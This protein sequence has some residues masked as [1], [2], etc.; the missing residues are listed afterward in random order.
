MCPEYRR[1]TL[2][3]NCLASCIMLMTAY[4]RRRASI[5]G[6]STLFIDQI[7]TFSR[8]FQPRTRV[9]RNVS[10]HQPQPS[11][12]WFELVNEGQQWWPPGL[13]VVVLGKP[14]LLHQKNECM[15]EKIE[16][17]IRMYVVQKVCMIRLP[18]RFVHKKRKFQKYYRIHY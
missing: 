16:S 8:G 15:A 1:F 13:V 12:T 6:F 14:S 17:E 9:K 2:P 4:T 7:N 11:S 10:G 3:K 5:C 18:F